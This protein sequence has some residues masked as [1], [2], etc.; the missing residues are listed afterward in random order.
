MYKEVKVKIS[1]KEI[2][3]FVTKVDQSTLNFPLLTLSELIKTW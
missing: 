1:I 3:R 2:E